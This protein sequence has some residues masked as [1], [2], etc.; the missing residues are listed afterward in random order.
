MRSAGHASRE[1]EC[2]PCD[3]QVREAEMARLALEARRGR[4]ETA[5]TSVA[6]ARMLR[7]A[8]TRLGALT[9]RMR[10]RIRHLWHSIVHHAHDT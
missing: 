2:S 4:D 1:A 9:T 8:G 10:R 5:W 3:E 7:R 6:L